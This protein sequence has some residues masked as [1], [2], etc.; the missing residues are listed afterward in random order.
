MQAESWSGNASTARGR[1]GDPMRSAVITFL[2]TLLFGCTVT[3][4]GQFQQ[5][6]GAPIDYA[7]VDQL[8]ENETLK[9]QALAALG[10]PTEV[11]STADGTEMLEYVSV[12]QRESVNKTLGVS[13]GRSRQIMEERVTLFFKNDV[14]MRKDKASSVH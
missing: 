9:E 14:L 4:D 3:S 1:R 8:K 13:H 5:I 6:K 2:V 11:T 12:K 10:S 7:R